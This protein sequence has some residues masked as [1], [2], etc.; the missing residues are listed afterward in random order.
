M[1][2]LILLTLIGILWITSPRR[3]RRV[4]QPLFLMVLT[5]VLITSPVMVKLGTVGL[6]APLPADPGETADAI[7]VLG[8]GD[9][10]RNRRI[11]LTHAL[12]LAKRAPQVFASGMMDAQPIVERLKAMGIPGAKLK[13]EGCSRDT[14]E[15]ALYTAAILYPQGVRKIILLTDPHHMLRSVFLFRS[16]GFTVFPQLS[17][18]PPQWETFQRLKFMAREYAGLIK[19]GVT[20]KF[21]PRPTAELERPAPEIIQKFSSWNCK[22]QGETQVVNPPPSSS[23]NPSPQ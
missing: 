2:A 14:E 7:V 3:W 15:N 11:E 9:E 8:R 12:W 1:E 6:T 22:I 23:P 20:G 5:A 4:I 10:L 19:Q 16:V 13:G 18:L 17:P 21:Q